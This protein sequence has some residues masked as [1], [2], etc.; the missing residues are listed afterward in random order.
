MSKHNPKPC[1]AA[2]KKKAIDS[3]SE[4]IQYSA[5]YAS[6]STANWRRRS[7]NNQRKRLDCNGADHGMFGSKMRIGST[8]EL[9]HMNEI[10]RR[11]IAD[12]RIDQT[13]HRQTPDQAPYFPLTIPTHHPVSPSPFS[14]LFITSPRGHHILPLRLHRSPNSS[15]DSSLPVYVPKTSGEVSE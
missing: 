4:K 13:C 2:E 8:G 11:A 1:T 12:G 14:H 7:S 5:R 9:A 6:E 10:K 3:Y 15:S